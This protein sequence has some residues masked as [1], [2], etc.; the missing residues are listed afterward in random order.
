VVDQLE[1]SALTCRTCGE[2]NPADARLCGMCASPLLQDEAAGEVRRVVTLVT[3]DLKGSTALGERLDPEALREVL[4]R[5]F[6]VMRAVFESHGG[7]IEK[8]IG[9]AI[10]AVFGLPFRHEDDPLRAL[11]AAAESQR[12]LATLNDELESGYGVRLIVRTGVATGEVTFGAAEAGQHVLLGPPVDTSTVM[13]QNSPPLEVLVHESTRELVGDAAAFEAVPPV[14]PK[15]SDELLTAFRLVSVRERSGEAEAVVP[16]SLPGMR[17]CP[18]CGDQAPDRM[19]YCTTCGASLNQAIA[20]ESRRTV[21]IVFAMPKVHSLSGE[22]PGPETMRDVMSRYFEGMRVALERHGGTVEKFIGDA[23]MAVFGLPVRHE[24][25]AV[26][27]I[28]A[29]ADMQTALDG[30]NPAFRTESGVELSNHIGV[31]SGEVIAGDASTAQRMVTGDAVNT[32]ARLEQA[33]GSGEVVLGDLTYRLARDQI[34][35]EFMPP[36]TLKGK[37]EP[38]PAYRLIGVSQQTAAAHSSGTPFV[39]REEEMGRLAGALAEA[40]TVRGARMIT[41]V[42][43]AGVGKSRLIREFGTVASQE[44]RLVRGRCLPYGDGITFWPLA[45]VVREAAGITSEDSPRV[46]TRRIDRLLE[47]AGEVDRDGIVERVAAAINLSAAQFPVAELMWGGRRLLETLA[48]TQPL[49]MIVDDL[50]WA[51]ATFLEFLDHL[52][53]SVSGAAV[54][55]LGTARHEISERHADWSTAH[56]AMLVKLEPLSESDSGKIVEQLLGSLEPSVRR[57]IAQA[58]EGNP[59]YVEQIVSM[60]VETGAIERGADGWEAKAGAAELQI[61][62]TVQALVAARLDALRPEERAVVD[63]GSVIGLTFALDAVSELVGDAVRPRLSDDLDILVGKQL[64][65]RL[66]EEEVLYRFGHQIIRDTAYGSLLKRVRATLHEQ[67]ATWADR[68][69]RERGRE[70]EFEEINGYHLEQAYRYRVD[71]GVIDD[72]ARDVA[73]RAAAKLSSAGRR[74]LARTDMPAAANLL[75]RATALLPELDPLRVE[76][77]LDLA[78]ARM[79]LGELESAAVAVGEARSAAGQLGDERLLARTSL[80]RVVL[81][82]RA[83]SLIPGDVEDEA[84]TVSTAIDTLERAGDH[85]GLARAWRVQAMLSSRSGRYGDVSRAAERLIENAV[86]AGE[87]SLVARGA[88]GYANQAVWSSQPVTEL[89]KRIE[90]FL[91]Q[92]HGDRKAEANISLA[93]AQLHA[94]QG[95]FDRARELYRRG[96]QLLRDLGPSISG[97]TTS[98]ASARVELLTGDLAAAEAELRRDEADLARLDERYYRPSIAG[99]LARVLLL[100]GNLDEAERFTRVAEEVA[101]PEDTDPQVLWRA[102]RARVLLERADLERAL[103]LTAEAV[104][105][106]QNTE[107]VILTADVLVDRSA[108][109]AAAGDAEA[110]RSSLE[111]ALQLY[112]RKGDV[113]SAGRIRGELALTAS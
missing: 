109:L 7:T 46:A 57:R 32:A 55:V 36:L 8:I 92:I 100:A 37:A 29:A 63:P 99:A 43:D 72:H 82:I 83:P 44:A 66:P 106:S 78:E 50:H 105:L 41:V 10:V 65:R 98:I 51:E 6:D 71:L 2:S 12:A 28:R 11:E 64:V 96:Q 77:L 111:A 89:T 61:P 79:E 91:E 22:A 54:L 84:A 62:P 23:V 40:V 86:S 53:E 15:G 52:I 58:A 26:R 67:F 88:S 45:E 19:R 90:G 108:V 73:G 70:L 25:D 20:R 9:D 107:D 34:E 74:A 17:I 60:L 93:L 95:E 13:E 97:M 56:E 68:V 16:E 18:S 49:V 42:G 110:A 4:N 21:T 113:I 104:D 85:A 47:R 81:R 1:P 103:Q 5:Y 35:V 101:D 76:L 102:V 112:E 48:A 38:V 27:A 87:D 94:M 31:N 3:S 59:L 33:A 14:S 39:G 30:L 75:A 24:D 69:N 80:I